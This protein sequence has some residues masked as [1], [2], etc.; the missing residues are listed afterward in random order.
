MDSISFSQ[1]GI[2]DHF[3]NIHHNYELYSVSYEFILIFQLFSLLF[4]TQLK[5]FVVVV[6]L[7]E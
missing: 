6:V 4:I 2:I 5:I 7:F 3:S 1:A